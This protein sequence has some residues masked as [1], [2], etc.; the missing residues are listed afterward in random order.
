MAMFCSLCEGAQ[1]EEKANGKEDDRKW[2]NLE[3][4]GKWGVCGVCEKLYCANCMK[5][6]TVCD[7]ALWGDLNEK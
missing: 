1:E 2:K 7:F 6:K 3:D 4:E 5:K